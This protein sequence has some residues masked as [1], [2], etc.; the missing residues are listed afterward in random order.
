MKSSTAVLF[1]SYGDCIY[2]KRMVL[3]KAIVKGL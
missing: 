1:F 3:V 2:Y